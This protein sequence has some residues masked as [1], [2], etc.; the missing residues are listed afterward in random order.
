MTAEEWAELSLLLWRQAWMYG[1]QNDR[2][3][4]LLIKARIEAAITAPVPPP[5]PPAPPTL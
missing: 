2:R 4:L 1:T 5:L 3:E